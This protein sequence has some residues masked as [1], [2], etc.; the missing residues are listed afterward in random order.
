VSAYRRIY[1]GL[2]RSVWRSRSLGPGINYFAPVAGTSL[3]LS[4]LGVP[5]SGAGTFL[6]KGTLAGTGIGTAQTALQVDDGTGNNRFISRNPAADATCSLLRVL[7][8]ASSSVNGGTLTAA[9]EFRQGFSVDGTGG[10][11]LSLNGAASVTRTGGPTTGFTNLRIGSNHTG[12]EPFVGSI[13][14]VRVFPSVVM[15]DATLRAAVL[16]L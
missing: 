9:V 7:A 14:L 2:Y 1:D 15:D 6:L 11:R 8:G 16:A 4:T 5:A 12:A 13:A 3:L 10:V